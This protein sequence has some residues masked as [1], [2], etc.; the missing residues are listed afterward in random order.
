MP[1]SH[2]TTQCSPGGGWPTLGIFAICSPDTFTPL[3]SPFGGESWCVVAP[4]WPLVAALPHQTPE[5]WVD[6]GRWENRYPQHLPRPA[7]FYRPCACDFGPLRCVTPAAL[8]GQCSTLKLI[9]FHPGGDAATGTRRADRWAAT[10][11]GPALAARRITVPLARRPIRC[12]RATAGD[13]GGGTINFSGRP[14]TAGPSPS[15][16][17]LIRQDRRGT[18]VVAAQRTVRLRDRRSHAAGH[19]AA[20]LWDHDITRRG[21]LQALQCPG[22]V[23]HAAVPDAARLRAWAITCW[24]YVPV[25]PTARTMKA[26]AA[27]D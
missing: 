1:T 18:S 24:R 14:C 27:V 3:F 7:I 16:P 15:Y 19:P 2:L 22:P 8:Y 25:L 6:A 23:N 13:R 5:N 11:A 20:G 10:A 21:Q 17:D 4:A 9:S 26:S 12:S